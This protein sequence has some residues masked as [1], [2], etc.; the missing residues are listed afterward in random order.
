M[1]FLEQRIDAK[2]TRGVRFTETVPGRVMNRYPNGRLVQNFEGEVPLTTCDLAHGVR[3]S[4]DFQALLD[5]WYIV[6]FTPYE[7][8]RVK[9]WRDY[10][11]T[12]TNTSATFLSGSTT[13]LQL[14]RL[15]TFGGVT[16]LRDIRKPCASPA[17][18]VYRTR[19]GATS[20]IA[21]TVDTTTGIATISGH[22]SGDTYTWTGE[23]DIPMTFTDN[24]WAAT[25]EVHTS[26]LHLVSGTVRMEE[27][28]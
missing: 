15:H 22:V 14:Q 4:A 12:Q 21:A 9:N 28:L 18:V 16:F 13:Q 20:S 26:N 3:S 19:T 2:I 10:I 11:A 25:L 24:E 17:V 23:F 8:L 5:A 27:L 7:G 1:A 6:N